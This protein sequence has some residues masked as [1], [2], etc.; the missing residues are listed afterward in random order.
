MDRK[1]Q[2]TGIGDRAVLSDIKKYRLPHPERPDMFSFHFSIRSKLI[3]SFAVL[4]IFIISVFTVFSYLRTI[5][6]LEQE[7]LKRGIDTIKTFNQMAAVYI[8]EK[9]FITIY[10][11]ARELLEN[12]DILRIDVFDD[13]LNLWI[14]TDQTAAAIEPKDPFYRRLINTS[15]IGHRTILKNGHRVIEFASPIIALDKAAYLVTMEISLLT[16]EHQLSEKFHSLIA[17]SGAMIVVSILLGSFISRILTHPI[18]QLAR[19][20]REI[21]RGRLDYRTNI[22]SADEIGKLARVFN[23]MTEHLQAEQHERRKT[24]SAL[25]RHRDQLEELVRDRTA[26]LASANE[27]LTVKITEH[28]R[29]ENALRESEERYRRLSEVTLEGIVFH[30]DGVFLDANTTFEKIS[31]YSREELI[32]RDMV[33][34]L[35]SPGWREFVRGKIAAKYVRPY[36]IEG[37]RKDGTTF[38]VEIQGRRINFSNEM[39]GVASVRDI[40]EK[41]RLLSRLQQAQKMEA[42]G[43]LAGGVAHDLN[44]ILGGIVGYPDL[45]LYQLPE[46]SP[47]K[48]P[49]ETIRETG[50][51]AADIVQNLLTLARRGVVVRE[52]VNFHEIIRSYLASPEHAKLIADHPDL[53]IET[54]LDGNQSTI[55]GSPVHLFKTLMNLLSNAAESTEKKGEILVRTENRHIDSSENGYENITAGE[56]IVLTVAD[57]GAG[58]PPKDLERI[59]EPFYTKKVMGKSGTGLGLAVVWGT[60]KDHGGYIDVK[61]DEG[62]GTTFTLYFP[63]TREAPIPSDVRLP[64][65]SFRG[66]GES[67]LVV[68][69]IVEQ[70]KIAVSILTTLGY[71]VEAVSSGHEAIGRL[72]L[73][74]MDLVL[75][76]MMM[77]PGMD[78]LETYRK[79]LEIRP[80]QKAL[81]SSGFSETHRVG[82]IMK[83]GAAGYVKK[84]Y[85]LDIIGRAVRSVLDGT[86]EKQVQIPMESA[87]VPSGTEN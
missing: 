81:V 19:G 60:V 33:D 45:L 50:L 70:Q 72:K 21:A 56:Y 48:K 8:F 61:S 31:G 29:T 55:S 73:R 87:R 16:I 43:M 25:L 83:L 84:P 78:G 37:I 54:R 65:S 30:E 14:S 52:S 47:L 53:H 4:S 74:T 17:L 35:V 15:D 51:R 64:L 20:A 34:L 13:K 9:D 76:D 5:T 18:R 69:D 32:G 77:E 40:T 80:G 1:R 79:I 44:N 28:N 39:L 58:I 23:T 82:K 10:D 12:E 11:N 2:V 66:K 57:N 59:F 22:A 6:T 24:E 46:G 86:P 3:L 71:K 42:I 62:K 63:V 85:T 67:V 36:E 75:I 38:P 7:M 49:I 26:N 27:K 68:D 41:K